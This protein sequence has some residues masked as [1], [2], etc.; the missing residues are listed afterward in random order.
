M[1][2]QVDI[3]GKKYNNLFVAEKIG[4]DE[5]RNTLYRCL[6][7]CGNETIAKHT[8]IVRG[9]K[10]SC[11]CL[12]RG[13][14]A[15][16]KPRDL[17]GEKIGFVTV[18]K[19]TGS[20]IIGKDKEKTFE[21]ECECGKRFVVPRSK[22]YSNTI[23]C[24]CKTDSLR[25]KGLAIDITGQTFGR[26][27]AIEPTRNQS[28]KY[29]WRCVCTCGKEK[30]VPTSWLIHGKTLSCGCL[31]IERTRK[32][33]SGMQFG[34]L[35][36]IDIAYSDKEYVYWN[37]VCSCGERRI[38]SGAS[39]RSGNTI[40]CG[41]SK[42]K[43]ELAIAQFLS[44]HN[45]PYEKE[46][47]FVG[48]KDKNKLPFDFWI[49]DRALCIEFDGQQHF[50]QSRLFGQKIDLQQKH[51]AIKT[52]YCEENDIILLRIP[53]WEKDN[54][55]SILNDWLFLNGDEEANSSDSGLSA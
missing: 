51:D 2:K 45:I 47:T 10:K 28:G 14:K 40:S 34:Q 44:D 53:Y 7:D 1:G 22:L 55:E 49:P 24:G 13:F 25:L 41:C 50:E 33:I 46:K 48:C 43:G 4:S 27:T 30:I 36:A 17:I 20:S 21:V 6:C 18:I 19:C 35:T 11:G 9:T 5:H 39:L 12:P 16:T 3:V 32:D 26:L 31:Q 52:K 23:N 38:I 8:Q 42:S 15:G 54:I 29:S 37:C